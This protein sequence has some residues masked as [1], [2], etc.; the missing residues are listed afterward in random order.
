MVGVSSHQ[1]PMK[2]MTRK[3]MR[4]MTP[5]TIGWTVEGRLE[6]RR[7]FKRI[8]K[9]IVQKDQKFS[10]SSQTSKCVYIDNGLYVRITIHLISIVLGIEL[11]SLST[12]CVLFEGVLN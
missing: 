3:Q 1:L 10:N 9:S 12:V 4:S 11:V 2:R 5:L 7:S 6:G 8:S